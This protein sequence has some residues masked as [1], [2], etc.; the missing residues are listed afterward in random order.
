[1][2]HSPRVS[3]EVPVTVD[4]HDLTCRGRTVNLALQGAYIALESPPEISTVANLR[5]SLA[6]HALD[7]QILARVVRTELQGVA[8]EFLDLDSPFEVLAPVFPDVSLASANQG[9]PLLRPTIA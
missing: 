7:I 1:M 6:P 2:R 3:V 8:V 5:F 9:L 4:T